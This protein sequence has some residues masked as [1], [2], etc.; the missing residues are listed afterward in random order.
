MKFPSLGDAGRWA[1]SLKKSARIARLF[2]AAGL[3]WTSVQ[4]LD[5]FE[6]YKLPEGFGGIA[7]FILLLI[8]V[9]ELIEIVLLEARVRDLSAQSEPDTFT[10]EEAF[11]AG[12]L[13]YAE[14][15]NEDDARRDS[16]VL[17][18]RSWASRTLHLIGANKARHEL[19][20]IALSAA[21]NIDDLLAQASILIDELGWTLHLLNDDPG[22]VSNLRRAIEI[23]DRLESAHGS[24]TETQLL[25]VKAARH[26]TNIEGRSLDIAANREMLKMARDLAIR[27]PE[28]HR[29]INIAQI[30]HSEG[31]LIL[32]Y[33][34]ETLGD[35]GKCDPKGPTS[36][37]LAEGTRLAR[38]SGAAFTELG[39]KER[40]LKVALLLTGLLRHS[41]DENALRS[42]RQR[43]A[44]LKQEAERTAYLP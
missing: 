11:A 35:E 40:E 39:D 12:I 27:L 43:L 42:A 33:L 32:K 24:S 13:R 14:K 28:P 15:L 20:R 5:R 34:D 21:M 31:A 36:K 22:A 30:D 3:L 29:A 10:P 16:A 2:G 8:A 9:F 17:D 41:R 37:L 6:I 38:Q 25:R 1:S 23:L 26:L 19:G 44:R 18:L 7:L 4:F